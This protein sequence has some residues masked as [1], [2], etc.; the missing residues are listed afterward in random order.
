MLTC[1]PTQCTADFVMI[2]A[3]AN[4]DTTSTVKAVHTA[5]IPLSATAP[6]VG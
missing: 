2:D 4:V 1:T 5:T 3:A 6:V